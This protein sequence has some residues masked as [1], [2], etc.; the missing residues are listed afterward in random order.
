MNELELIIALLVLL[1]DG[2]W[3]EL[4]IDEVEW[5]ELRFDHWN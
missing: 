5:S 1:G 4:E 2:E 3:I